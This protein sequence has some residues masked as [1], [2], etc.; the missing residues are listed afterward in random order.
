MFDNYIV[1]MEIV[2][3]CEQFI[4][5]KLYYC[6]YFIRSIKYSIL[7]A[8]ESWQILDLYASYLTPRTCFQ[9]HQ[10]KILNL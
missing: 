7:M 9:L 1:S 3:Q 10:K 4:Y 8:K 5:V 2:E 6:T